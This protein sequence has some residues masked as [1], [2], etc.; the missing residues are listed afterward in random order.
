MRRLNALLGVAV[1]ATSCASFTQHRGVQMGDIKL[2]LRDLRY[3]SG[4]RVIVE[5]DHS[6]HRVAIA[7][8][9]GVG[10]A[11]EPAGKEGMAHLIEHLA[12]RARHDGK[13]KMWSMLENAGAGG[14]NAGTEF[15]QTIYHE[16]CA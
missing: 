11:N 1:F 7:N 4:L 8:V 6:S 14:I 3:A 15:D 13:T 12:F 16:V 9:V 10:S 5:E 2:P